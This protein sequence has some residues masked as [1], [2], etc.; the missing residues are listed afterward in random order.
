MNKYLLHLP[1]VSRVLLGI[2][3]IIAGA[4]KI[5]QPAEFARAIGNYH[6]MPYGLENVMAIILPWLEVIIGSALI[7]GFMVDGAAVLSLGMMTVFVVAISSAILRGYNIECGCGLKSGEMV[8]MGKII[9][10][11]IYILMSLLIIFRSE[12]K[13]ECFPNSTSK[14]I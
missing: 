1:I 2:V 6:I 11:S 3:L 8:G 4:E 10:D 9:E 7:F 5:V 13:W 12:K 14:T